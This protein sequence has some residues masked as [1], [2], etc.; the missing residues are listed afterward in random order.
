M[1]TRGPAP[2]REGQRR[3]RN[4]PDTPVEHVAN[5]A[6]PEPPPLDL[7]DCH[8][9]AAA[10]YDALRTSPES[11]YLTPA[12]WQRAR[13]SALVLSQQLTSGKPSAVM[14]S[15]LQA[16]WKALLIDAGELRRLGIEIGKA[17]AVDTDELAAVS[18]LDEFR[19][20]RSG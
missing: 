15:A 13:V 8:P 2:K 14:Y 18:A 20:A 17:E 12:S 11:A 16:D 6:P 10:L 7:P 3:R 5:T 4:K 19:A 1:G 9:L